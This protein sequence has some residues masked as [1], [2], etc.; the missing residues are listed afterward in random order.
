[1]N[2]ETLFRRLASAGLVAALATTGAFAQTLCKHCED[3]HARE[4]AAC[5]GDKNCLDRALDRRNE[6]MWICQQK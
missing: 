6:C 3:Q 4:K 1:M 2:L 5:R